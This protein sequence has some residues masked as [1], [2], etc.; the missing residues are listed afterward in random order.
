MPSQPEDLVLRLNELS[1]PYSWIGGSLSEETLVTWELV[2]YLSRARGSWA[3][4]LQPRGP[5]SIGHWVVVD[6]VSEDGLVL[7]RDP[8]GSAYGIPLG[9]FAEIWRYTVLVLQKE[10]P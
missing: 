3:A 9:D 2:D 5:G 7:V 6:G 8:V 10:I 1:P 4:L